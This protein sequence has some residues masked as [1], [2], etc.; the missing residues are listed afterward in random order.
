MQ[1]VSY[2]LISVNIN[3]IVEKTYPEPEITL[4]FY[5]FHAQKA[6][7]KVP[8]ICNINFWI[9]NN[10]L[11]LALFKKFIRFGSRILPQESFVQKKIQVLDENKQ[12]NAL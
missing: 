4:L 1:I 11:P 7:F 3:T 8:K 6:L 2:Q 10:P 12:R 9:E 5:Q